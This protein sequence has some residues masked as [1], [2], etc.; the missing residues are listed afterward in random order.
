MK[1]AVFYHDQSWEYALTHHAV[2]LAWGR[3]AGVG[4]E[5]CAVFRRLGF[6]CE[7]NESPATTIK[8]SYAGLR[9]PPLSYYPETAVATYTDE[10]TVPN[11][12][13]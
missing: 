12:D 10:N 13:Y 3:S 5:V 11:D 4:H 6:T 1:K 2:Y 7:W 8:V 9:M